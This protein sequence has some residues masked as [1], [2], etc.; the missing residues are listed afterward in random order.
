MPQKYVVY[1]NGKS[2]LFNN[3]Q[4]VQPQSDQHRTFEGNSDV[5]LNEALN[6]LDLQTD[7]KASAYMLDMPV[8]IG[9][10]LLKK[11]FHHIKAAGGIVQEPS[12]KILMIKRL[13]LWDLPKGKAEKG[14]SDAET[15]V[16]E[17][18][19]ETL[20]PEVTNPIYLHTTWHTYPH[21]G[22]TVLKESVWFNC[23]TSQAWPLVPQTEEQITEACWASK[24]ELQAMMLNTYPSIRDVMEVSNLLTS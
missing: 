10:E 11:I 5:T 9:L 17:I 22:K 1:L 20:I 15:A 13:G 23:S 8:S 12:G 24:T 16:R 3:L 2:L 7:T 19:E 4:D 21:K 6:W 18:K 14:E